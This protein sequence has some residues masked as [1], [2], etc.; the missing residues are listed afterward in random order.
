MKL[1]DLLIH[2]KLGQL[3]NIV[4]EKNNIIF[5]DI[6]AVLSLNE[7]SYSELSEFDSFIAKYN[8]PN[9]EE[10][11]KKDKESVRE[12]FPKPQVILKKKKMKLELQLLFI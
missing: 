12:L 10:F 2:K 6:K 11:K 7:W 9:R 8:F 4:F 5:N 3:N 1:S